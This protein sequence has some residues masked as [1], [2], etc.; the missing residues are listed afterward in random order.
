MKKEILTANTVFQSGVEYCA[1]CE[2]F[3]ITRDQCVVLHG[4]G[5]TAPTQEIAVAFY[6]EGIE[7]CV[8]DFGGAL[9]NFHGRIAPFYLHNCR[10]VI[11]RNFRIDYDRPFYSQME[12]VSINATQMVLREDANFPVGLVD[13]VFCALAP[14]WTQRLDCTQMLLQPYDAVTRAPAWHAR[15]SLA[16]FAQND[17]FA[18]PACPIDHFA[19]APGE[20]AGEWIVS[21]AM[22]ENWRA[23]QILTIT[24]EGR[25]N[26]GVLLERCSNITVENVRLLH[27]G[28]MG[29][30][31]MFCHDLTIRRFDMYLDE[32]SRGLITI[33]AD[34]IHCFHCTG[35][36]LI[37][38]CIFENMLDDAIN[39]HGNY[40]RAVRCDGRQLEVEVMAAAAAGLHWYAPGDKLLIHRG[41]T[42]DIRCECTVASAQYPTPRCV[43]V[44]LTEVHDD[45][46][47]GDII[48]GAAVP[49]ITIRR[50]IAG[51]NRP[52]G[53]L[54]S[55]GGKT[56]VEDCVFNTCDCAIHFT[57]DTTYWYE[58]GAVRDVT[59]RHCHFHNCGY[60]TSD[61]PIKAE[62]QVA[63]TADNPYFHRGIRIIDNVFE[64]F[65]T[66]IFYGEKC[67]TPYFSGNRHISDAT[68]PPVIVSPVKC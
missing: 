59:I 37:E 50:C 5:M 61:Y 57:G 47:S 24:H 53:F 49:E 21:G 16:V 29:L 9:L 10:N 52:R 62:P 26:N 45:I 4:I 18:N 67:E 28:S 35:Q 48:E 27:C 3:E 20:K 43:R 6:L 41:N 46:Q 32:H 25:D 2:R 39:I 19:I 51:K 44:E 34:S 23:G 11:L 54:L 58:S 40:N 36:I 38:D 33:N 63:V 8:L 14:T 7:D 66:G 17:A 55:S 42:T 22:K 15:L 60:C 56:L 30:V 12:I 13:G 65:S 68:Y 31:A 64:S 1:T